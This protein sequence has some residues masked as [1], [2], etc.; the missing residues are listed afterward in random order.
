MEISALLKKAGMKNDEPI[1]LITAEEALENFWEAIKE[2]CPGLKIDK[3]SKKDLKTL[4]DSYSDCV[5]NYHSENCH[6]E[7]AALLQN[8]EMLTRY[9]LTED[10]YECLDFT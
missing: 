10:D 2:Y 7:R 9:G 4:L 1:L 3:M 5:I 6:Q 8:F